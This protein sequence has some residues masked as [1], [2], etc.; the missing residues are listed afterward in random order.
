M[1]RGSHSTSGL[2]LVS[3]PVH[4]LA[5]SQVFSRRSVKSAVCDC[6]PLSLDGSRA[7][8]YAKLPFVWVFSFK[9]SFGL[10]RH[11]VTLVEIVEAAP[12]Y[13]FIIVFIFS[14][15]FVSISLYF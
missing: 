7:K 2:S 8:R 11:S 13:L 4:S 14:I 15:C 10:S 12:I 9:F 6:V 1:L 5:N 3:F